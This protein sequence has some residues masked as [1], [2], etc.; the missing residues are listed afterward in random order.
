M[1]RVTLNPEFSGT[2]T[3]PDYYENRARLRRETVVA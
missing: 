3:A 2:S 1:T